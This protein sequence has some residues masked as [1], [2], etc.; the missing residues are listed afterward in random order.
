MDADSM[1]CLSDLVPALRWSRPQQVAEVLADP[2][3][4]GGWWASVAL[5]RALG[6]TGVDWVCDRLSRL[7]VLRWD[8]LALMDVLPALQVHTVDPALTG[9]PEPARSAI[10]GMGGWDRLR[11]LTAADL[12]AP[13]VPAS[14]E[15]IITTVFREILG[16]VPAVS[17]QG[18]PAPAPA[19]PPAAAPMVPSS[20]PVRPAPPTRA[21]P[22]PAAAAPPVPPPAPTPPVSDNPLVRLVDAVFR[23]W[24]P[25][26][27]AVAIERLF[28]AEP[29][30]L[31]T[32]AHE[33]HVD[34]DVLSQAQRAA[35]ERVLHWLRSP[36]STAVTGHLFRL[37]EWLGTAA[38]EEQLIAADPA[39]PIDVP[40]LGT[41]LW[42]VL[43][44]LMPDRRLQD[45][46][47]VVGDLTRLR[48]RS[49]QVLGG[50]TSGED[51]VELLGQLGI[52]AHSAQAWIDSLPETAAQP[53]TSF[54]ATTT[55][56]FPAPLPRRTPGA[57]GHQI[58]GGMPIPSVAGNLPDAQTAQSALAAL[59]AL[60]A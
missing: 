9:W 10:N 35:E 23:E 19:A 54:S 56:G 51:A 8:H 4:P 32:L 39:H 16:R 34:R 24:T 44:A 47:L 45:G 20:P 46:W 25:M 1:I 42:R 29:I 55:G 38:T 12:R 13:A 57:N 48:E 59:T 40:S 6:T 37:T 28:A 33:L 58:R 52:R 7:A 26:E 60:S 43:V 2:R 31:R 49:V 3:L 17:S 18:A 53:E 11:R 41:P 5:G 22:A 36:E 15:V 14:A 50:K 21:A 27:R 30:S